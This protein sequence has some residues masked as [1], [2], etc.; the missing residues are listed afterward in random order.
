MEPQTFSRRQ[1]YDLVW[2]EPIQLLAPR[3]GL[4]DRGLGK[5]CERHSVPTPPRGYWAKKQAGH[6]VACAPLIELEGVRSDVAVA[7]LQLPR[8]Q[9]RPT[10]RD[11]IRC[12]YSGRPNATRSARSKWPRH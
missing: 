5:L 10:T 11:L 1:L 2:K 3:F 6:R 4:S 7:R 8:A 12:S 9:T